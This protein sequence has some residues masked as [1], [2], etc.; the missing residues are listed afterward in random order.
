MKNIN[1]NP[2]ILS[3]RGLN[4]LSSRILD[5]L[6]ERYPNSISLNDL[7]K[8]LKLR[9]KSVLSAINK[10]NS[11]GVP[12]EVIMS[13]NKERFFRADIK[14][15]LSWIIKEKNA[16]EKMLKRFNQISQSGNNDANKKKNINYRIYKEYVET[17]DELFDKWT[18]LRLFEKLEDSTKN[19]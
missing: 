11:L 15:P 10:I 18:S 9:E 3:R 17:F 6:Y 13:N 19:V 1:S 16:A 7:A 8:V 12:I 4:I 14:E 2:K 5:A